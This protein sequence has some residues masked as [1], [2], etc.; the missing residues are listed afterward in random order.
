MKFI[1]ERL[2]ALPQVLQDLIGEFNPQHRIQLNEVLLQLRYVQHANYTC[3]NLDCNVYL[4]NKHFIIKNILF[5][6]YKFCCEY[7]SEIG[8]DSIRY[9]YREHHSR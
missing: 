9:H 4:Y 3:G 7:C 5:S 2:I 1:N 8:E 6:N